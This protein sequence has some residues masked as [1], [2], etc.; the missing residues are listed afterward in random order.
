LKKAFNEHQETS[1]PPTPLNGV[2]VYEK[3]SAPSSE[4][5]GVIIEKIVSYFLTFFHLF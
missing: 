3:V 4:Q 5:S 1:G 2:K